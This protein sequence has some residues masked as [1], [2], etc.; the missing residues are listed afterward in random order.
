M[1]ANAMPLPSSETG[2]RSSTA[3][4]VLDIQLQRWL[5]RGVSDPSCDDA[6]APSGGGRRHAVFDGVFDERLE[7]ERRHEHAQQIV[8]DVDVDLEALLETR[9]LD[10]QI[11]AHEPKFLIERGHTLVGSQHVA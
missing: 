11:R 4:R 2:I 3:R 1:L 5:A 8:R 10:V 9:L 6:N 7:D